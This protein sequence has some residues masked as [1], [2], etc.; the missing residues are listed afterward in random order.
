SVASNRICVSCYNVGHTEIARMSALNPKVSM[1]ERTKEAL[2]KVLEDKT[3]EANDGFDGSWVAHP[4]LVATCMG[5]FDELLLDAPHQIR[6]NKREDVVPSTAALI[7]VTATS[8]S[9]TEGGLD[10][11]IEVG[12]RYMDAWLNGS[13]AAAI[14]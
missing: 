8:G 11:N 14:N 9:I 2:R 3:R 12:I 6:T 7:H 10:T 5:V 4:G 13:G 1:P